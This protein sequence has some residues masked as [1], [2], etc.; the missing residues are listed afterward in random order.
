MYRIRVKFTRDESVKF[1]SHLDMMKTFERALRRS[2]LPVAY[3]RGFNPHP[4]M[5]F[6]LPLSVGVTSES[7]YADFEL[8]EGIEEKDLKP[9]DF[10]SKM[11]EALPA[12]IRILEAARLTGRD[13]IMASVAGARYEIEIYM[14]KD[15]KPEEISSIIN[16]LVSRDEILVV[17][18]GKSGAKEVNIR[19]MIR[20]LKVKPLV[21][22]PEAYDEF[23]SAYLLEALLDAGSN[24][25]LKP[26]LLLSA[27]SKYGSLDIAAAMIHRTALYIHKDGK[28]T[29]PMPPGK[30]RIT[31][32]IVK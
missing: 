11:N 26:E 28:L 12:G 4:Q 14:R 24:S 22:R 15:I 18:E 27:L 6:G 29:D 16:E 10:A 3:T 25:N 32:T 7:E 2:G 13:N 20:E 23:K 8:A 17:K 5:V 19:N 31:E 30:V 21:K 1:I 9:G